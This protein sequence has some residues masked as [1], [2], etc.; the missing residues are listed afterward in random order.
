V[1]KVSTLIL[2]CK[3]TFHRC[4]ECPMKTELTHLNSKGPGCHV[5]I[6]KI[7]PPIMFFLKFVLSC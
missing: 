1:I 3:P 7:V 5:V 6:Y 2:G 4:P